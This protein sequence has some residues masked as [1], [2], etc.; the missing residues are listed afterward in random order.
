MA[1]ARTAILHITIIT[2]TII[3]NTVAIMVGH[4][5]MPSRRRRCRRRRC[6][7]AGGAQKAAAAAATAAAPA[8]AAAPAV[9]GSGSGIAAAEFTDTKVSNVRKVIAAK[10]TESKTT[11]PH[12]YLT[13]NVDLA[14]AQVGR[15]VQWVDQG[16]AWVWWVGGWVV[17][18]VGGR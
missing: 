15:G 10:L 17:G 1:F 7:Q 4:A 3:P 9:S 6:G 5:A 16:G 13:V 18:R 12:Y 8:A 14:K 11:V 2:V